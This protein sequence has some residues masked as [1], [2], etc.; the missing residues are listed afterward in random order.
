M[1]RYGVTP[2]ASK[3]NLNAASENQIRALFTPILTDLNVDNVDIPIDSLLD[4]L[5]SDDE[6][7]ENGAEADYYAQ[8][9]P[10]YQPKNGALDTVEELLLVRG[11]TAA[12]LWGEDTN[13]NGLLDTVEDD[14]DESFPYYDNGDGLLNVGLA[15]YL[16]VYSREVDVSNDNRAR[17]S[18]RNNGATVRA[19]MDA[20]LA[21]DEAADLSELSAGTINFI[22]TLAGT[23]PVANLLS[24]L[25]LYIED[26]AED[27]PAELAGSPVTL[28]ELPIVV[29][30]FTVRPTE[31]AA[32]QIQ[33][34]ININ[35]AP[36][37]VLR[38]VPGL[39]AEAIDAILANREIT[40]Q[41]R[42]TIAWPLVEELVDPASYKQAAP[43]LTASAYQF[44]VEILAYG[45]H[46][47]L[48][49][50]YEYIIEMQGPVA[51]FRYYRDLTSLGPGWPLDREMAEMVNQ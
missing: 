43:Y 32:Q 49:R 40:G 25:D 28:A 5:D 6:P 10:P 8:L 30:R 26:G 44:H 7:R 13:R 12:L 34:L 46:T 29:D 35:T 41:P 21:E 15:P 17:I 33:G 22:T 11:I 27:V 3:L 36:A 47:R 31:E 19:Q 39:D 50:R 20:I 42:D 1:F 24:P 16:T 2:E 51:Q 38:L 48:M 23:D 18:L 14:G 45:D 4:W 9:D 37:A